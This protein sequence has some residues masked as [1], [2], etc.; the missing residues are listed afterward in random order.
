MEPKNHTVAWRQASTTCGPTLMSSSPTTTCCGTSPNE[1]SPCCHQPCGHPSTQKSS[2]LLNKQPSPCPM[3]LV[4]GEATGR[5]TFQNTGDTFSRKGKCSPAKA[6]AARGHDRL[7]HPP[8][9]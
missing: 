5:V 1:G 8:A 3:S 6:Q 4:H 2:Q 7:C 9:T